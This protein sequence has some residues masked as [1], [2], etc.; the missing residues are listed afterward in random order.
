MSCSSVWR[1]NA[2]SASDTGCGAMSADSLA[3]A[4][5]LPAGVP[6][7]QPQTRQ[8]SSLVRRAVN[9]PPR[10]VRVD[11][12]LWGRRYLDNTDPLGRPLD[13]H[14]GERLQKR[15]KRLGIAGIER[16]TD[17]EQAQLRIVNLHRNAP[18]AVELRRHLPQRPALEG[19]LM[20]Y[21]PESL[22]QIGRDGLRREPPPV[23]ENPIARRNPLYLS[24]H[25]TRTA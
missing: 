4:S 2:S 15:N 24:R 13:A 12:T 16:P 8:A 3:V 25:A 19:D 22:I 7:T 6:W 5:A 14:S 9:R 23:N 1:V 21:P 10:L 17:R 11:L 18:I 20:M